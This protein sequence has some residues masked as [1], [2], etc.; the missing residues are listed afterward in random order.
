MGVIREFLEEAVNSRALNRKD[1]N[2]HKVES[3][4]VDQIK[5]GQ[6]KLLVIIIPGSCSDMHYVKIKRIRL[7][8]RISI[9]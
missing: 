3:G 6:R 5:T 9:D 8:R 2:F 1:S 7:K 4:R